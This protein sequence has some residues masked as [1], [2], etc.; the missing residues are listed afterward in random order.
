MD[1]TDLSIRSRTFATHVLSAGPLDLLH[2][3]D[4]LCLPGGP[5]GPEYFSSMFVHEPFIQNNLFC[6]RFV[7]YML[8]LLSGLAPPN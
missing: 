7:R 5:T 1:K 8:G 4:T 6:M 2:D 3:I